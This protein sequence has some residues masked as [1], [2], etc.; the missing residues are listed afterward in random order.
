M[1]FI[2]L[3]YKNFF[4]WNNQLTWNNSTNL[5]FFILNLAIGNFE[6]LS[7][8]KITKTKHWHKNR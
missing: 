1:Y 8:N 3:N 4:I 6:S 2:K 7:C 5:T